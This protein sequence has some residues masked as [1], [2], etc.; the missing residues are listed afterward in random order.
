MTMTNSETC[1]RQEK[2]KKTRADNKLKRE[3]NTMAS[4]LTTTSRPTSNGA[5]LSNPTL[6]LLYYSWLSWVF[7]F[8]KFRS[9]GPNRNRNS[10]SVGI[11]LRSARIKSIPAGINVAFLTGIGTLIPPEAGMLPE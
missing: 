9:R 8:L 3:S 5:V 7:R 11:P 6:K 4:L 1:P 2:K 10:G